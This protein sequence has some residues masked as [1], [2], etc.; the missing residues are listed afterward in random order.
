MVHVC[1]GISDDL[2]SLG[3]ELVAI[4]EAQISNH[5]GESNCNWIWER[6][7]KAEKGREL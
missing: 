2:D 6:T 1:P 3:E 4:L 7:Y 5:T